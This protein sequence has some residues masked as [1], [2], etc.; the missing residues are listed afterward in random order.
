MSNLRLTD[1]KSNRLQSYNYS[2]VGYYFVTVCANKRI[3]WFGKI[4][5][6]EM[7]LNEYGNIVLRCWND[8]PNHYAHAKLDIFT[9]MPNHIHGII[10]I[11]NVPV[12]EGFKP[13]PTIN[14][15]LPEIIRG[16][17]T[18][19]SRRINERIICGNRFQWQRSFYDQII[20]GE[21]ALARMREY[22]LNNPK[23][24]E[25]DAENPYPTASTV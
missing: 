24:W 8:L 7:G 5:N 22:I 14:H 23:K 11:E 25:L 12:G 21:E 2:Q 1:R 4:E 17:K 16:F 13:S 15:G 6:G 10:I 9:I 18:F 20:R 19:S 3:E